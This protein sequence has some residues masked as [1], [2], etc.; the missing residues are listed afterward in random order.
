MQ[1]CSATKPETI[2]ETSKACEFSG[3]LRSTISFS[4]LSAWLSID[5]IKAKKIV[6]P[7]INDLIKV[8]NVNNPFEL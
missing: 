7:P 6:D 1:P 5:V 4:R 8:S 3:D 2:I